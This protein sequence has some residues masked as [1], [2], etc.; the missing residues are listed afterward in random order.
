MKKLLFIAVS[1]FLIK[2]L[3]SGKSKKNF[4]KLRLADAGFTKSSNSTNSGKLAVTSEE[5]PKKSESNSPLVEKMPLAA[6]GEQKVDTGKS[7]APKVTKIKE[8]KT[9]FTSDLANTSVTTNKP[10]PRKRSTPLPKGSD[11]NH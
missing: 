11:S 2:F 3:S 5:P 4:A 6:V 9:P 8:R 1:V 7:K 10:K